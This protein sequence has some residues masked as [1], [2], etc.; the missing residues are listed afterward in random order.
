MI[1]IMRQFTSASSVASE[2]PGTARWDHTELPATRTL[3]I[4]LEYTAP[5]YI[6]QPV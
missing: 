6:T 3:S 1:M 4:L 2:A 5:Y